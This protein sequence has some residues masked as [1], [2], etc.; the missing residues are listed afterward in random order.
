MM[1]NRIRLLF[2]LVVVFIV[3]GILLTQLG[4]I[5]AGAAPRPSTEAGAQPGGTSKETCLSCH[6][7]FNKLVAS[8]NHQ[9]PSGEK[10]S[11][12]RYVPHNPKN[13][14]KAIP[15][16]SNCHEPHSVALPPNVPK[17]HVQWCYT[18]CHHKHTFQACKDCHSRL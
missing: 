9:A 5:P 15:E 6:G 14:A 1:Q 11:P 17:G 4:L 8:A 3:A 2:S 16:C 7:P 13:E 18:T 12:H 10:I